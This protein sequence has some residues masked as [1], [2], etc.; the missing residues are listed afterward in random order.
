MKMGMTAR[1]P[2]P[3]VSVMFRM[4]VLDWIVFARRLMPLRLMILPSVLAVIAR[5]LSS[6]FFFSACPGGM[7]A[8]VMGK[9]PKAK[10][11]V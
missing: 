8:K 11:Q 2:H 1:Q 10:N 3:M 5:T 7:R 6:G 4:A 9:C